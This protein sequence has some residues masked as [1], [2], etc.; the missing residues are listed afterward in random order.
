MTL[1]LDKWI[2]GAPELNDF[3]GL[4]YEH[5]Y[6]ETQLRAG[7]DVK[8]LMQDRSLD[9]LQGMGYDAIYI[10]GTFFLNMP[11]QADSE[12]RVSKRS[13]AMLMLRLFGLGLH[14]ARPALR[15]HPRLDRPD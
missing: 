15:Y 9:Y 10:A 1:L 3:F 7:G 6:R 5:D 12:S 11:W 14:I 2:D 13:I 4:K 8:G